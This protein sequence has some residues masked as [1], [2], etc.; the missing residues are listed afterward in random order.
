VEG[1]GK[2]RTVGPSAKAG[3]NEP[4]ARGCSYYLA[5]CHK[6]IKRHVEVVDLDADNTAVRQLQI[7]FELPT[8]PAAFL[9]NADSDGKYHFLFPLVYIRKADARTGFEIRDEHGTKLIV[10]IRDECDKVSARAAA[11]AGAALQARLG[12]STSRLSVDGLEGIL[13]PIVTNPPFDSSLALQEMFL[14]IGLEHE[15]SSDPGREQV[16]I[17]DAWQEAG[18]ADA[19]RLLV[20]HSL[21]W[22]PMHGRPGERRTVT[23]TQHITLERRSFIRWI[24]RDLASLK[25]RRFRPF[26]KR[27]VN[28][29]DSVLQLGSKKYGLRARRISFSVLA[30]RMGRPIAWTPT[31]FEFPTIYVK[32]CLSYHFE[33]RSPPGR[34]PRDLR[35]ASGTPLAEPGKELAAPTKRD[36]TAAQDAKP[37]SGRTTLTSRVVR[38][39]LQGINPGGDIWFRVS[40]GI[41]DGAFPGLWFLSGAITAVMLWLLADNNPELA[42]TPAQIVAGI[43]LIVPALVAA[44]VIGGDGV[45]ISQLIGGARLLFLITGLSAV[46]AAAVVAGAKPYGLKPDW[47]WTICAIA[48]TLATVPLGTS[49]I[50]SSPLAWSQ[51]KKLKSWQLQIAAL[52]VC[53][54]LAVLGMVGLILVGSE[55]IA[56]GTI[57]VYLL[58]LTMGIMALANNRVAMRIGRSRGTVVFSCL[59]AGLV[60]FALACIE[61]RAAIDPGPGPEAV[62]EL[63]AIGIVIFSLVAGYIKTWLFK[64]TAAKADEIHISPQAG[65]A[66]LAGESISELTVLRNRERTAQGLT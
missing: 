44:L 55:S 59:V 10:P 34:T 61:L 47:T 25:P 48:A 8:D 6:L 13:R 37:P 33:L 21:I 3:W 58:V 17:G 57:A 52:T 35:P 29:P 30:E 60:C 49:W 54:F 64:W 42:D 62:V 23:L 38:H 11:A 15:D 45:P 31:E 7:D 2:I 36:P 14:Q 16:A 20:E 24:F 51:L 40:I 22:V 41:G 26:L 65:K 4:L 28:D 12:S 32:R 9:G 27:R 1:G 53:V 50:L 66:L 18:L 43:L 5:T 63:V 19:L 39:D 46:G 56:E